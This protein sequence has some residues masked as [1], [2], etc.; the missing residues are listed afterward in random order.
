M[1]DFS[2]DKGDRKVARLARKLPA[3]AWVAVG[4]LG[5]AIIAPATAIAGT[6]LVSIIGAHGVHAAV[7]PDGQLQTTETAP[8]SVVDLFGG[9]VSGK[10]LKVYTVPHGKALIIENVTFNNLIVTATGP[11]NF[12]GIYPT[13]SCSRYFLDN[14]PSTPGEVSV[15]TSP[16]IA[17]KQGSTIYEESSSTVDSEVYLFGYLVPASE[18]S[19]NHLVS[20]A[21][22]AGAQHR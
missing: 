7:T 16:G 20:G 18:V 8:G 17:L 22:H 9:Q 4:L 11:G 19:A 15:P 13:S 2:T 21:V 10:C 1:S 12:T 5:A 6:N 14:N 3:A